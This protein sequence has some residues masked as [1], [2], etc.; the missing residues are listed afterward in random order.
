MRTMTELNNTNT[1]IPVTVYTIPAPIRGFGWA[2]R[3]TC[4]AAKRFWEDT[5]EVRWFAWENGKML[6]RST[7]RLA[8]KAGI[9]LLHTAKALIGATR[10]NLPKLWRKGKETIPVLWEEG[11]SVFRA[12]TR[13]IKDAGCSIK[14]CALSLA[15]NLGGILVVLALLLVKG[16]GTMMDVGIG[17]ANGLIRA[18]C[19]V[20]GSLASAWRFRE[21]L[22]EE[23]A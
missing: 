7:G 9:G 2:I 23:W 1:I 6:A 20:R 13:R 19:W 4:R 16:I 21:E 12:L 3:T 18:A 11:R 15:C 8:V 17:I 22:I 5:G 10:E 14:E